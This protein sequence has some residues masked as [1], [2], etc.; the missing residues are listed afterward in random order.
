MSTCRI[1]LANLPFPVTPEASVR[2]AQDAIAEAGTGRADVICFPECFVP[3]YRAPGKSVPP[4]DG[5]F[6]ERAWR[7]VAAAA[8]TGERRGRPRHR[9]RRRG[10][11]TADDHCARHRARRQDGWLSGQGPDRSLGR[12][13][14]R[15]WRRTAHLP[16]RSVDIRRR[17]LSRGVALSGD[18]A[19][20]GATWSAGG[21]PSAVPRGRA[22]QLIG[23]RHTRNPATPFTRRRRSA[24]LPRTRAI[25]RP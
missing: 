6:L 10:R 24:A 11:G 21:V 9:T 2:L 1:A 5:A 25:S 20:G 16:I 7:A 22:G 12:G 4:P 15:C 14:L 8:A 18:G 19:L 3:G 17:H 23:R 13:H